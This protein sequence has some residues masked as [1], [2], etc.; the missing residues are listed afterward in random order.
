MGLQNTKSQLMKLVIKWENVTK[1]DYSETDSIVHFY[2]PLLKI[3]GWN[4][5][6]V[7]EVKLEGFPRYFVLR[8]N[9]E[10]YANLRADCV[11]SVTNQPYN[12]SPYAVFEYK[13]IAESANVLYHVE[14]ADNLLNYRDL[15]ET[16]YAVLTNFVDTVIYGKTDDEPIMR[17]QSPNEFIEKFDDLWNT[18]SRSAATKYFNY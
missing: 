4:I 8:S 1:S 3:L 17:F 9:L 16:R 12:Y 6:D 11:L 14:R 15:L 13:R 10:N 18:L 7:N 2:L 5:D